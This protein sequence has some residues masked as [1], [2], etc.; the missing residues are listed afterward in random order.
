[1]VRIVHRDLKP[2]NAILATDGQLK[3]TDFGIARFHD[4]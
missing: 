4:L 1:M 2:D 3:L